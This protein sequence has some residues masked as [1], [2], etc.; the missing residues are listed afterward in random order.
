MLLTTAK[1]TSGSVGS[2]SKEFIGSEIGAGLFLDRRVIPPDKAPHID[3]DCPSGSNLSVAEAAER[4]DGT[5][6]GRVF[7]STCKPKKIIIFQFAFI[8]IISL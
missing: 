2:A 7:A 6:G 8:K 5:G 4:A 1:L 3:E